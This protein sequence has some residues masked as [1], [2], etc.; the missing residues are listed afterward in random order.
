MAYVPQQSVLF[1]G[2]LRD[3]LTMWDDAVTD[4]QLRRAARDACIEDAILARAG[5]FYAT[6]T[7]RDSGFSGGEMQRLAIARALVRDPAVLV[8]DEAT[9]ALDPVVEAEVEAEPAPTRLHVPGGGASAEHHPRCRRD[10]G[11]REGRSRAARP[12]STTS[13][14]TGSS[15]S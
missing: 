1:P 14:P 8:L 15:R 10:P 11:H 7:G 3:N 4:D 13:R 9:S 2:T 5:G 12:I 6:V